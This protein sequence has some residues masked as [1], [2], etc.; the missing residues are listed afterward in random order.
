MRKKH[1]G[2]L[3]I[4]KE[5]LEY[6]YLEQKLPIRKIADIENVSFMTVYYRMKEHNIPRRDKGR[7]KKK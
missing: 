2:Y 7:R 1:G 3:H 5:R 4:S 6:L